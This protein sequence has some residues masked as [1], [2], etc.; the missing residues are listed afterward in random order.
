MR[1]LITICSFLIIGVLTAFYIGFGFGEKDEPKAVD[2]EL[3]GLNEKYVLRFSHVV[4]ENTPKGLAASMFAQLVREKTDGWVE[5]QVFPNASLYEAQDEFDGLMRN[6]IH[7]IAPALSEITVLD[8]KWLIMDLPYA[9]KDEKMVEAAFEGKIGELLFESI[10]DYGFHGIAYWDNSF[11]QFTNNERPIIVPEDFKG[12]TVRVMPSIALMETYRVIGAQP[13]LFSFN[14][15]YD[16]LSE[17]MIDGTENT[18]SNIF[19]KGF[20]K[21][22]KY[23]T[24]SNHN[25]LGYAVFMN[26][27]YWSTMPVDYQKSIMEAMDEVTVWLREHSQTMNEEMLYRIKNSGV[28]DIHYQTDEEKELWKQEFNSLYERFQNM[29][30]PE[31]MEELN[32]LQSGY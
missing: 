11:K 27:E 18:L 24:L 13:R 22:Q 6:D 16:A 31:L 28:I 4:A 7:I 14:E 2:K 10:K 17:G 8:P 20:Y 25:Y 1:G 29:I 15:V 12:L 5:V 32:R 23:M 26:S 9:F 30:G 19:S 3:E 21:Q